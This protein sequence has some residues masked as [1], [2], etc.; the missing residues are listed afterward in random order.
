M[1]SYWLGGGDFVRSVELR[2][3][4]EMGLMFATFSVILYTIN[5]IYKGGSRKVKTQTIDLDETSDLEQTES[6][7]RLTPLAHDLLFEC[8]KSVDSSAMRLPEALALFAKA[9]EAKH[10]IVE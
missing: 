8:L 10:G 7:K 9:I 1:I 3:A 4:Y 2:S 6:T 5:D